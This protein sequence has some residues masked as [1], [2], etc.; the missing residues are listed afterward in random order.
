MSF[1]QEEFL[2]KIRAIEIASRR[3][4]KE[5]MSGQYMSAFRGS[6]MQFKEFRNYVYGDDVRHISWNV[7]ARTQ[8]PVIKTFDEERERTLFLVVDVSASLRRGPWA[9]QKAE[10]LAE[11]AATLAL[12]AA[13][14]KDKF[15]LLLF[16]EK[17]EAVIPPA[18]GR[19]HLLRVIRDVLGFEP[20]GNKTA[21]DLALRQLDRVLKK[22][23]IVFLLTDMEVFPDEM[24]LRR[25]ASLHELVVVHVEH[26][27]EWDIPQDLGFVE[28]QTAELGRPVTVDA[29]SDGFRRYLN[30]HGN[31]RRAAIDDLFRRTS[32]DLLRVRTDEDYV[33]ILRKYFDKR[34]RQ[35]GAGRSRGVTPK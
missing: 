6:G 10:K 33:P 4:M 11:I 5:G 30:E 25:T 20:H 18:K 27:Q 2:K 19:S 35:R 8:E 15:G 1:D 17:V 22:Q 9:F 23:A 13:D 28:L 32:V 3:L 21:P 24:V 29:S 16:S 31:N 7:S 26:A 12:S 14:A 34:G